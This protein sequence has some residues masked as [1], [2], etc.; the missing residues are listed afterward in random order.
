MRLD[1][2]A[3]YEPVRYTTK[4]LDISCLME[5]RIS[6]LVGHPLH[7]TCNGLIIIL[8]HVNHRDFGWELDE[9]RVFT[10][11]CLYKFDVW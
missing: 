7:Y 3:A 4:L 6:P 11:R 2:Y 1:R 5:M 10:V 8:V 9:N